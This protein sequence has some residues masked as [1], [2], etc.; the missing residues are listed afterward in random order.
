[1]QSEWYKW[2]QGIS[3]TSSPARYSSLQTGQQG[4]FL[5]WVGVSLTDGKASMAEGAAGG[6]PGLSF[7]VFSPVTSLWVSSSIASFRTSLM[8]KLLPPNLGTATFSGAAT[9]LPGRGG[10]SK[11][12]PTPDGTLMEGIRISDP[13]K[14]P[15]K[16]VFCRL[17][18]SR[19]TSTSS[20]SS[21]ARTPRPVKVGTSLSLGAWNSYWSLHE[22]KGH[23]RISDRI[24]EAILTV[25]WQCWH[26]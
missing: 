8:V 2:L 6:G 1:M 15:F 10:V 4:S 18:G 3:L 19:L 25:L 26:Q 5:K 11:W 20:N 21:A 7:W 24:P 13:H 12:L 23:R 22:Q 14:T 17:L 9:G 16:S